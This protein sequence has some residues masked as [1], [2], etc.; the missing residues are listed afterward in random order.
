M[1]RPANLTGPT[2]GPR[3]G[4]RAQDTGVGDPYKRTAKLQEPT[5]CPQCGAVYHHGRWQWA[6]PPPGAHSAVCQA[7][8][9]VND[10]FPAGILAI[11]GRFALRHRDEIRRIVQR[12]EE[13]EKPEHPFNR[14]IR[15][16]D[17]PGGIVVTTTDV[18]L[19]RRIGEALKAAY[20]GALT[21]D[22]D[23]DGYF[24]RARWQRDD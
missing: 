16:R 17:E 3:R 24:L 21:L 5:V 11:G 9:R 12:Q 20:D 8:H 23:E 7:C 22:Y 2:S 19:P 4:G 10:N 1:A 14:I 13:I 18:H 15:L 6:A